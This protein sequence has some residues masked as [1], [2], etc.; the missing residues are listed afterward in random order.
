MGATLLC[1]PMEVGLKLGK[2]ENEESVDEILDHS[3][4]GSLMYLTATR[5]DLMFAV[6]MLS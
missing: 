4:V 2:S 6:S 1:T 3:L 5:P